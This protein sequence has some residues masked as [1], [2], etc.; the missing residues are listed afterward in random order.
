[1][2]DDAVRSGRRRP[3]RAT[4]RVAGAARRGARS[5]APKRPP[6]L[7][8]PLRERRLRA[9]VRGGRPRLRRPDPR[10]DAAHGRQDGRRDAHAPAG[11]PIV[12]GRRGRRRRR[13]ELAARR[14]GRLSVLLKAVRR[15]RRQGDAAVEPTPTA[16]SAFAARRVR[17]AGRRSATGGLPREADRAPAP[18]RGP[19]ARRRHGNARPPR[20]ARVQLP[21]PAP[22]SRR[23]VPVAGRDEPS[24]ASASSTAAVAAARR[25]RLQHAGTVEF[26]FDAD[27]TFYFLEMNTRLQVEHPVTEEVWGV[28]L[29]RRHDPD[30]PRAS[31]CRSTQRGCRRAATPWSAASTPRTRAGASRPRPADPASCACPQGP[32]VRNDVGVEPGSVVPIDYDPMLG[33]LVVHA[34]D[35][36]TRDRPALS[37][38]AR[39]TRSRA[40][41]PRCRSSARSRPTPISGRAEFD[42]QWLDRRLGEDLSHTPRL[43]LPRGLSRGRA[44]RVGDQPPPPVDPAG[45]F[46]VESAGGA[47]LERLTLMRPSWSIAAE[48]DPRSRRRARPAPAAFR[49]GSE[50]PASA[51]ISRAAGRQALAALRER[52]PDLRPVLPCGAGRR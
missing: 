10:G 22:E 15:R 36:A 29:G 48:P 33:K 18:R 12:P 8:L 14:G 4:C 13:R 42:V 28:D 7:R 41:R 34:P 51:P 9:G 47:N 25:R 3:P 32:G 26:L 40:S 5:R 52:P 20:R 39:N 43:W 27:G 49:R 2:A 17:S 21:A 23:G 1:M 11:V 24:C 35:R 46:R 44:P 19:G 30:R 37:R 38:A 45:R 31:R 16:R 6:R 50:T